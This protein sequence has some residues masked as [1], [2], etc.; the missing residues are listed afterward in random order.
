MPPIEVPAMISKW[1]L[2]GFPIVYEI[3]PVVVRVR[4]GVLRSEVPIA[5]ITEVAP[6]RNPLS[7]PAMSLDRL[8]IR[9]RENGRQR[10]MLVSPDDKQAF[11]RELAT[12]D[13]GLRLEGDRL[14]RSD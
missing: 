7:A 6:T 4:S 9:Y 10:L 2:I 14:V 5:A 11:L 13:R 12:R 3:G 8:A 1:S